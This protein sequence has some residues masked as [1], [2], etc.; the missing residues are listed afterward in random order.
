MWLVVVL[1]GGG[2]TILLTYFFGVRS[3][4]MQLKDIT[5]RP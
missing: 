4:R 3:E 1:V 2:A 5:Q